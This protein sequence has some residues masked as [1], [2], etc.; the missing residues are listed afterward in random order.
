VESH[1]SLEQTWKLQRPSLGIDLVLG[2][3]NAACA[4]P[5][6]VLQKA[7]DALEKLGYPRLARRI[8]RLPPGFKTGYQV[9]IEQLICSELLEWSRERAPAALPQG[10]LKEMEAVPGLAGVART[11]EREAR[12]RKTGRSLTDLL[13]QFSSGRALVSDAA[14]TFLTFGLG[15]WTLGS[16]SASLRGIAESVAQQRAHD[17]AASR[18]VL[19]KKLG[20]HFYNV[21]PPAVE[22]S[23]VWTVLVV[24]VVGLTVGAMAC[25]ILSDPLRKVLGLHRNRLEVLLDDIERDL[26]LL[27]HRSLAP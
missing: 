1:F 16:T 7:A 8:K 26:I 10:F 18:F 13:R 2:P 27:T 24:L 22:E 5:Y 25:T 15:W 21:F 4:L 23:A 3:L 14:G 9:R 19:G 17:R 20:A 6:V 11:L 12:E